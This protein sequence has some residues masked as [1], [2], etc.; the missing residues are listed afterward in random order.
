MKATFIGAA[1]VLAGAA[2]LS[3]PAAANATPAAPAPVSHATAIDG[4]PFDYALCLFGKAINWYAPNV[5]TP[6]CV[7]GQSEPNGGHW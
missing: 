4:G 3:A 1:T 6:P 7:M 2:L 5:A